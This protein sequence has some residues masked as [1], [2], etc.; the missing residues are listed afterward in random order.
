MAWNCDA[1]RFMARNGWLGSARREV[2]TAGMALVDHGLVRLG[3]LRL[4]SGMAGLALRGMTGR[5]STRR[6]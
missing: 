5:D 4:E 1:G 2:G 3:M 6:V